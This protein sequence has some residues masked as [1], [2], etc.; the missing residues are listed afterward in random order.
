M[1]EVL[2]VARPGRTRLPDPLLE[3]PPEP[4][5][6]GEEGALLAQD[7]GEGQALKGTADR[8]EGSGSE[9]VAAGEGQK[10]AVDGLLSDG[11]QKSSSIYRKRTATAA[12]KTKYISSSYFQRI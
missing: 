4:L 5:V 11:L 6:P 8:E 2:P 3:R 10:G 12:I 1:L 7:V 9:G